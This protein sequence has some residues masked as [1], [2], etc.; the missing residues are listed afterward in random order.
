M[1]TNPA[2][3]NTPYLF[4]A[5][6]VL[7][8]VV[9]LFVVMRPMIESANVLKQDIAIDSETLKNKQDFLSSLNGKIEQLAV[10]PE[11]EKQMAVVLPD[12]DR[13]QDTLRIIHEYATQAGLTVNSVS[14]NSSANDAKTNAIRA[15]GDALNLPTEVR[16]LAFTVAVT[17]SYEQVKVFLS[18]L[19]KSPR[20]IDVQELSFSQ[21]EAQPG[22]VTSQMK[23]QLYSQQIS[24]TPGV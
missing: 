17:G 18:L 2:S 20:V 24:R 6:V 22:Q 21:V 10:L 1:A 11:V 5:G 16:T 15:R 23:M 8:A 4:L 14:N 13:T 9:F 7:I 19:G 12:T 3:L